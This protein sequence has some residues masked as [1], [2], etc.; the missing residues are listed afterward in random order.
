[1]TKHMFL[2]IAAPLLFLFSWGAQAQTVTTFEG[3]DASTLAKPNLDADPNGAVGT[4][5]YMEWVN[6][7]YQA[8]DKATSLPVWSKPQAGATPWVVAGN[9]DCSSI[10]G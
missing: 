1:M 4:K 8:Y 3:M 2:H 5:Q 10:A 6:V 7:Y 9:T